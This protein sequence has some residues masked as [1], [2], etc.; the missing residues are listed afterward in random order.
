[1][2][3][4][5]TNPGKYMK[6]YVAAS[7]VFITVVLGSATSPW[8]LLFSFY[9]ISFCNNNTVFYY[10]IIN[11]GVLCF[12][13]I[14][15][16]DWNMCWLFWVTVLQGSWKTFYVMRR[17]R[18]SFSIVIPKFESLSS[19][20]FEFKSFQS[21]KNWSKDSPTIHHPEVII[22]VFF[23]IT[24]NYFDYDIHK[25]VTISSKIGTFFVILITY[26]ISLCSA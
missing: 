20:D 19:P 3:T 21:L 26:I 11:W 25:H 24:L 10:S 6:M 4:E 5:A 12:F 23:F 17:P 2:L 9:L 7:P 18:P 8:G 13:E 1:M 16:K 14:L 22:I 15:C